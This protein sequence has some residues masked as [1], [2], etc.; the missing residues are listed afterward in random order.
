MAFKMK[1]LRAYGNQ[2][3]T[4]VLPVLYSYYNEGGDV[5][6]GAGYCDK[7]CGIVAG[8]QVL[9]IAQ[10]KQSTAA[11]YAT[12]DGAGVITLVAQ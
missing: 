10:N 5:V 6:T 2:E 11:H 12:V 9:V 4:G 3:A 8:D 1:N 7:N